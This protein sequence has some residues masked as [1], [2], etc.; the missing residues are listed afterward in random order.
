[1]LGTALQILATY[2]L[3]I[4]HFQEND[5]YSNCCCCW[6]LWLTLQ[7]C[8]GFKD[9]STSNSFWMRS[10][11]SGNYESSHNTAHACSHTDTQTQKNNINQSYGVCFMWNTHI[12]IF[13][14]VCFRF[15]L[16]FEHNPLSYVHIHTQ[17]LLKRALFPQR[18]WK[19]WAHVIG[20]GVGRAKGRK[21]KKR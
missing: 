6:R 18:E 8:Q 21:K 17:P 13:F 10:G 15:S 4:V 5:T 12:A 20:E 14:R 7:A 2:I 11:G 3:D 16:H 19:K 9:S 1:M